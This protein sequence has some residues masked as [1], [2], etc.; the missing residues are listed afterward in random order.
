MPAVASQIAR[1]LPAPARRGLGRVWD[2]GGILRR[3]PPGW[4]NY[5][6]SSL[7]EALHT[8]R[9]WG[10]PVSITLEPTNV[11]NL[12]C[13]VCETGSGV[14]GREPAMMPYD[15]FVTLLDK[16]GPGAN[17][18]MFYFMGEPFLNP[19]AY[20]MVRYARGMD[21]YVTT[22]TNGEAVDPEGLYDC[23][24]NHTSFQIGGVTQDTHTVYRRGGDLQSELDVLKRYLA[25]V[26]AHGRRPGE[27]QVELGFILMKHNEHEVQAFHALAR[28]LG[29]DRAVVISPTVRTPEQADAFL[30]ADEAYWLFDRQAFERRR[31]LVPKTRLPPN[32]CPWLYFA[33]TIQVDG[34]VVPCCRDACGT[35]VVG[36]LLEEPLE[37]VW[38]GGAMRAFR[39]QVYTD[40][41]A[42]CL[43]RRCGAYGA[44]AMYQT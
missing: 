21:L 20:R 22:C 19:D 42:E 37:A 41:A 14:L 38:N 31:E 7:S 44:P 28:N 40:R 30:P 1:H 24:I 39:R 6:L 4:I 23:G 3:R 16:V 13:P 43:C 35:H 26:E 33:I 15:T 34:T 27:H 11:C 25:L 17:H 18:L 9:A 29:V 8:G 36:N 2:A 5:L 32:V 12:R 10:R